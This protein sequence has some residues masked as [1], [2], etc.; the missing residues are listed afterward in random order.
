MVQTV[1]W[2]TGAAL[3]HDGV[4]WVAIETSGG[5]A[6]CYSNLWR[7]YHL[8]DFLHK[9]PGKGHSSESDF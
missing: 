4:H 3:P 8:Q 9:L 6:C 5:A 7:V 1:C 2:L